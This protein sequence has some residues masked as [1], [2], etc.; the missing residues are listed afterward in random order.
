MPRKLLTLLDVAA[1]P[2]GC[3]SVAGDVA[4]DQ[5]FSDVRLKDDVAQVGRLANGLGLYRFRYRGDDAV[6]VGVMAQEVAAVDP[7][8]VVRGEDGYLRVNYDRLGLRMMTWQEWLDRD[9][10]DTVQ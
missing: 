4:D 8:A 7:D 5:V 2:G 10:D 1:A 3:P 6:H 9:K